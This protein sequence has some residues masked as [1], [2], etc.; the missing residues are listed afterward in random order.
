[1]PCGQ[2]VSAASIWPVWLQSSSIAC[3]PMM[4]RPGF[5]ASTMALR[6][7]ATASGSTGPSTFTRMPRSAPMASAV[8]MVSAACCG[9]IE[10]AMISVA[11]P[12]SFSRIASST[13]ISSKGFIDIFTLA[14]STPEPS[15]L[16]RILMSLSTT[17]FTGT[18]IF[19]FLVSSSGHFAPESGP[20]IGAPHPNSHLMRGQRRS[21][22][23]RSRRRNAGFRRGH[24]LLDRGAVLHVGPAQ[25]EYAVVG[26]ELR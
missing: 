6:I 23:P 20:G 16:T 7:L 18:T 8:R 13:A 22:Q 5:S 12:A 4:T 11:L 25:Q 26:A 10:T 14:S 21:D 15:A 17:R 2:P 19:M 1:M 9:P 24:G 3:L